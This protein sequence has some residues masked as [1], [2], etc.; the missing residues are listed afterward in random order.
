MK[1]FIETVTIGTSCYCDRTERRPQ[2]QQ[3]LDDSSTRFH[4][5][6]PCASLGNPGMG[7]TTDGTFERHVLNAKTEVILLLVRRPSNST[8][9]HWKTECATVTACKCRRHQRNKACSAENV[10]IASDRPKPVLCSSRRIAT[11]SHSGKHA[12]LFFCTP[13]RFF[14]KK[15]DTK[16]K[17]RLQQAPPLLPWTHP[18]E[19][20]DF[21]SSGCL[22]C[23]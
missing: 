4:P 23:A 21:A 9:R 19:P 15:V 20:L 14:L 6:P 7:R 8:L 17:P 5:I 11:F 2:G 13:L 16:R 12:F 10:N 18:R 3:K 1:M 22:L